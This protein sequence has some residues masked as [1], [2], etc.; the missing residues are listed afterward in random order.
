MSI[1]DIG[2]LTGF[3]PD[4]KSLQKVDILLLYLQQILDLEQLAGFPPLD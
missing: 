1:M 4:R 3:A 2:I